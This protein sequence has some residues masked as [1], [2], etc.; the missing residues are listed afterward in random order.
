MDLLDKDGDCIH[1]I[2]D[3]HGKL[4]QYVNGQLE[5]ED[6][7]W[8]QYSAAGGITDAKGV[9]ELQQDQVEKALGL[10]ALAM[11]AGIEWRGERPPPAQKLLVTD[12]DG[13]RLEFVLND[14][15]LQEFNNGEVELMEVTT[16]C[17]KFADGSI[18]DDTGVF[19]LPP[20][21]CMQKAAALYSLALEAGIRWTGDIPLQVSAQPL[22]SEPKVLDIE[23]C[24]GDILAAPGV[25]EA[26]PSPRQLPSI[27]FFYRVCCHEVLGQGRLETRRSARRAPRTGSTS[28]PS[29]GR[30]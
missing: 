9:F 3:A 13:D 2:I 4:K 16:M 27:C 5:I 25:A 30:A 11:R 14:G 24:A 29:F 8:L 7:R 28:A 6:V 12:T 18:T 19:T 23:N 17:F 21:E 1:F 22:G 15:K 26:C 20:R 10:H